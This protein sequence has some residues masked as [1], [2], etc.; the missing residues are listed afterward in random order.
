MRSITYKALLIA[1]LMVN[2]ACAPLIT[3]PTSD[4]YNLQIVDNIDKRKFDVILRSKDNLPIC[5]SVL[6]WPSSFGHLHMGSSIATLH[7]AT[8]ELLAKDANF[9][10]CPGGCGE[11]RIEPGDK[12]S[13]FIAYEIFG[14]PEQLASDSSK[15]LKFSVKPTYCK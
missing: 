14:D 7:A 1:P 12:L 13:G 2:V 10:Y 11:Y 15:Q 8:G 9:G 4:S 6:V 3:H 5:V